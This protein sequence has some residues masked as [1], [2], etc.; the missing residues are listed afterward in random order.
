MLN[1]QSKEAQDFLAKHVHARANLLIN[2]LF[3]SAI[4]RIFNLSK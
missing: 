3:L 1:D 4:F 2:E